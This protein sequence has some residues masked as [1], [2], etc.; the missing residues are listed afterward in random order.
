MEEDGETKKKAVSYW[1]ARKK[2]NAS[3]VGKRI[4]RNKIGRSR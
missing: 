1:F 2:G 3:E 4:K